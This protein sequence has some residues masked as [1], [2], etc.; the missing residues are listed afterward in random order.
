MNTNHGYSVEKHFHSEV[1]ELSRLSIPEV[2]NLQCLVLIVN[3]FDIVSV[4]DVNTIMYRLLTMVINST[5]DIHKCLV[6]ICY[7]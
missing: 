1:H 6:L 3:K 7:Q 2:N 4:I 5:S